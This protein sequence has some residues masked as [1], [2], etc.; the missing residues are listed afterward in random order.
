MARG[1]TGGNPDFGKKYKFK[2]KE[3][4]PLKARIATR[5]SEETCSRISR[6]AESK[7]MAVPDL[8]RQILSKYI[9]EEEKVTA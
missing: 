1:R 6:I 4:E 7:G 9:D 5:V 8:V 3:N 2:R